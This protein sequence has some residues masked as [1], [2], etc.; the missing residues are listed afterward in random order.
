MNTRISVMNI[1]RLRQIGLEFLHEKM[2]ED[3]FDDDS[4]SGFWIERA[5]ERELSGRFIEKHATEEIIVDPFG[6]ELRFNRVFF[7]EQHFELRLTS[8]NLVLRDP[9][10]VMKRLIGRLSEYSNFRIVV[11][12][13]ECSAMQLLEVLVQR[14]ENVE[15]YAMSFAA[16]SVTPDITVRMSFKGTADVRAEA[17]KFLGA[18]RGEPEALKL[19]F[20]FADVIRRCELRENGAVQIYGEY[21]PELVSIFLRAIR[22]CG[23]TN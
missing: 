20:T 5:N 16:F 10:P 6:R 23:K 4:T 19:Q 21:E 1:G 9:S 11:M 22:E 14:L 13:I 2:L 17:R 12:P 15:T 8:P 3:K 18:R 7:A